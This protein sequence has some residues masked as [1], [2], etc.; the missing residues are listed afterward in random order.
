MPLAAKV[1]VGTLGTLGSLELIHSMIGGF[2]DSKAGSYSIGKAIRNRI[3]NNEQPDLRT[4]DDDENIENNEEKNGVELTQEQKAGLD[5]LLAKFKAADGG[6]G[7]S[8]K[9]WKNSSNFL[10]EKSRKENLILIRKLT[11][12]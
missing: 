10:L 12:M 1:I 4:K 11:V 3:K 6:R 9:K 8:T 2:T 7:G 5:N